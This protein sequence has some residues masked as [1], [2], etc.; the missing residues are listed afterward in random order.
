M[1][2]DEIEALA[3]APLSSPNH[4]QA[5]RDHI[6]ILFMYNT[7]A[8]VSEVINVRIGDIIMPKKRGMGTVTLHGKG[9]SKKKSN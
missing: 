6:I 4:K 5:E 1:D 3:A 8:R 2:R 9:M 7:G